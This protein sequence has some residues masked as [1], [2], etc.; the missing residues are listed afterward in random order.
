MKLI[1]SCLIVIASIALGSTATTV[2]AQGSLI[3]PGAPAPTM[4]SLDQIEPRTPISSLPYLITNAGS[5]YFT[6]NLTG[7]SGITISTGNVCLDL[8][9]FTLQGGSSGNGILIAGAYT[10]ITIR[11]GT[12]TG[13]PSRGIDGYNNSPRNVLYENLTVSGNLNSGISAFNNSII[14]NCRT[15]G[16]GVHGIDSRGLVIGCVSRANGG[17]GIFDFNGV[18]RDCLSETNIGT[19][20]ECHSGIVMDC[21][22]VNN[23]FYG[24]AVSGGTSVR[25]CHVKGTIILVFIRTTLFHNWAG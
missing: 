15:Y 3:P 18:I 1:R 14:R 23:S 17:I 20:I 13:W 24:I 5:Y 10:N 9:G 2:R 12:I 22:S 8:T 19:G 6:T 16:N 11:N 4:K 21:A 7:N 25:R